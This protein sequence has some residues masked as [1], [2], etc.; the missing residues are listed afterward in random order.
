MVETSQAYKFKIHE[1]T[2]MEQASLEDS[3]G[4][5]RL[6]I[7][8]T[9]FILLIITF[10]FL[11]FGF[12]RF[13]L[14]T[15][16]SIGIAMCIFGI[17]TIFSVVTPWIFKMEIPPSFLFFN[18]SSYVKNMQME[19]L[20]RLDVY[21]FIF[22]CTTSSVL[23]H[24]AECNKK[25]SFVYWFFTTLGSLLFHFFIMSPMFDLLLINHLYTMPIIFAIFCVST[26]TGYS[27]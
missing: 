7:T 25:M 1:M 15:Y 5:C 11:T 13:A 22:L 10:I 18:I 9:F 17:K 27:N 12:R 8:L 16:S 23:L 14:Y 2:S 3:I 6:Y 4:V 26:F 19:T 21:I 24:N 20:K